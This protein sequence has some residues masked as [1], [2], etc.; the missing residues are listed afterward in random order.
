[1]SSKDLELYFSECFVGILLLFKNRHLDGKGDQ[2]QGLAL[3]L[4]FEMDLKLEVFP[5]DAL[6]GK[7]YFLRKHRLFNFLCPW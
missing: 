2:S 6:W 1:M 3:G 7:T 4:A 5:L